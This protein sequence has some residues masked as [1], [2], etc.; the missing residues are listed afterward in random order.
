MEPV[1]EAPQV[2]FFWSMCKEWASGNNA[3]V[4]YVVAV[5]DLLALTVE[6]GPYFLGPSGKDLMSR[7]CI[8]AANTVS[9]N[10]V[11]KTLRENKKR[12]DDPKYNKR[13]GCIR[14]D[15]G[16]ICCRL[17]QAPAWAWCSQA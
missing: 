2:E 4:Q 15:A 7:E 1:V 16:R 14:C 5:L 17:E 10:F 8:E 9:F 13:D 12:K 11:V 6:R 3:Q